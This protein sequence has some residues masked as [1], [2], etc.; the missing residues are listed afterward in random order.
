MKTV[1]ML[2]LLGAMGFAQS[3]PS[4]AV[5]NG[6]VSL[7]YS[8]A[9]TPPDTNLTHHAAL[10]TLVSLW[11]ADSD[12]RIESFAVVINFTSLNSPQSRATQIENLPDIL[13]QYIS[14]PVFGIMWLPPDVQIN[15]IEVTPIPASVVFL[16][17]PFPS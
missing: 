5:V 8:V 11:I 12:S 6:P 1:I 2:V 3:C 10:A 9:V 15:S 13:R 17:S 7:C 4:R 14:G 16:I